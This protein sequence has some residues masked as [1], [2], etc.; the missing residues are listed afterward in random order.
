M[1]LQASVF[2]APHPERAYFSRGISLF[3]LRAGK[4]AGH[5]LRGITRCVMLAHDYW[6]RIERNGKDLAGRG[7]AQIAS[8]HSAGGLA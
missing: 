7:V 1:G 8:R 4:V 2:G 6:I 5:L 3:H